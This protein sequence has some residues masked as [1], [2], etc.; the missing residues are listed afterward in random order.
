MLLHA[1]IT[2]CLIMHVLMSEHFN[3]TA[4][5][6][7]NYPA[8]LKMQTSSPKSVDELHKQLSQFIKEQ[9]ATVGVSISVPGEN[10]YVGLN[11]TINLHAASTMKVPVMIEV[12]KQAEQGKFK[13][14]DSILIKNEFNSIVDGSPY[15]LDIKDD[16][17]DRLYA[18]SGAKESIYKLIEEMITTSG[19]LATNLLVQFVG[20]D[21]IQKTMRLLGAQDIRI[22]RG[23]EDTKAYRAGLNNTTTARDLTILFQSIMEGRAGNKQSTESMLSILFAQKLN[24]KIPAGLPEGVRVAHKTGSIP[25]FVDHDAGI[26]YPM[27]RNPYIICILTKGFPDEQSANIGISTISKLVYDWYLGR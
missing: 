9:P 16:S 18:M 12:F 6:K 19:N 20:A 17:A 21:H 15:S 2:V 1:A 5:Q 25:G 10:I 7:E 8:G 13:L 3:Q 11:D 23:V 24:E 22:L 27:D 14:S 4:E 26:I